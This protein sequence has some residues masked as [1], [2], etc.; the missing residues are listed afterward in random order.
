M[1]R[2]GRE[3]AFAAGL[4]ITSYTLAF[5]GVPPVKPLQKLAFDELVETVRLRTWRA[6]VC[7]CDVYR[8][9]ID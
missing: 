7:A 6:A 9:S 5:M 8:R 3:R 1:S 2:Y 4:P